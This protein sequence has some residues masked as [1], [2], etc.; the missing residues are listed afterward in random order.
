MEHND[1]KTLNDI[2][3]KMMEIRTNTTKYIAI[4]N[5]PIKNTTLDIK[6]YELLKEYRDLMPDLKSKFLLEANINNVDD[7]SIILFLEMVRTLE[8]QLYEII[9]L[10]NLF[11]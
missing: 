6:D 8:T 11:I 5:H 9:E 2:M 10:D 4:I 1:I 7:N 3:D